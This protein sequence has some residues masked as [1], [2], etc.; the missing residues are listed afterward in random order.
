M[1]DAAERPS[2]SV[3]IPV[4]NVEKWLPACLDSVLSQSLTGLEVICIDDASPDRC[5][6]ILDSY[7][8]SDSRVRVIH[9]PENRRQGYG[10]NRGMEAARGKY[11]YFLD[12]DDLITEDA[13][14]SLFSL[15]ERDA[16]DGVFFDSQVIFDSPELEAHFRDTY[17]S[18]RHGTYPDEVVTGRELY[19]AFIRQNEWTCYVQRQ[20]WRLD[21]LRENGIC[22]PEDV[23]HED[24]YFAFAAILLAER[25]RYIPER[26][27]I[28]R[29]REASVMTKPF[30]PRNLHGYL[31]NL[32]EMCGFARRYALSGSDVDANIFR[33]YERFSHFYPA[34]RDDPHLMDWFRQP[35]SVAMLDLY[36]VGRDFKNYTGGWRYLSDGLLAEVRAADHVF[37]Y[38]AGVIGTRTYEALLR[39]DL[40][41]DAFL[42]TSMD[43]N[44]KARYGQPVREIGS[45]DIPERS[46]II[47]AMKEGFRREAEEVLKRLGHAYRY[48]RS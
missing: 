15:C 38:G 26:Y 1:K 39:E 8:L 45:A 36:R 28:R 46:L 27:F 20:F 21:F 31:M 29:Y 11:V 14:E 41:I 48:Y 10:R 40:F 13:M 47:I 32:K 34:L 4:Y 25:I 24:E 23:E 30:G 2:V 16:L 35:E 37:I 6:A 3:V 33:M 5:P 19:A 12:S 43:G 9:L 18:T 17:Q 22:S 7:A 42:V 44:P